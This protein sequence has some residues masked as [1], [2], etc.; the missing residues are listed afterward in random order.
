[1]DD[2]PSTAP[3]T[4]WLRGRTFLIS[5]TTLSCASA[6][7]GISSQKTGKHT[8]NSLKWPSALFLRQR[9]SLSDEFCI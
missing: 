1:M 7:Y 3:I 9:H 6:L 8:S 5:L 4:I 2:I